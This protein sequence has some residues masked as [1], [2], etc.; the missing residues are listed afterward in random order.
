MVARA[1]PRLSR[2]ER[3]YE[4]FSWRVAISGEE[5]DGWK[6]PRGFIHQIVLKH[7]L[8]SHPDSS[9]CEFSVCGPPAMLEATLTMLSDLGVGSESIR[10]DVFGV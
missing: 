9:A 5:A 8:A 7:Y 2:L 10:Y 1:I 3:D 4:N 6:G